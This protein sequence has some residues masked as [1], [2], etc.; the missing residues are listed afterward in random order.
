M[1]TRE[2]AR[3][4]AGP[5]LAA[6]VALVSVFTRQTGI[7]KAAT[8]WAED[9]HVFLGCHT[10]GEPVLNCLGEA[11]GGYLHLVPRV[12]ALL[13]WLAPPN[14]WSI[15]VTTAAA[16]ILG[17]AAFAIAAALGQATRSS[18]AG[19]IAGAALGLTYEAG[20]EVAGNLAN[21]HWILLVAA[22][23]IVVVTWLGRAPG[24]LDLAVVVG[25]ALSSPLMP[26]VAMLALAGWL[27]KRAGCGRLL[28]IT[29]VGSLIQA[30]VAATVPRDPPLHAPLGPG[31]ALSSIV[32]RVVVAGPFG[33]A[34][35]LP[36]WLIPALA[37]FA[38]LGLL[39]LGTREAQ[40]A[41]LAIG[42]L[43]VAGLAAYVTAVLVNRWEGPR[44]EYI[45]AAL[46]IEAAL[47]GAALLGHAGATRKAVRRLPLAVIAGAVLVSAAMSYRLESRTSRGP[48]FDAGFRAAVTAC[49]AGV[50]SALVPISPRLPD[51]TWTVEVPCARVAIASP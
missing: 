8:M 11:Y 9:G 42:A 35:P 7:P 29:S 18:L 51:R 49:D 4:V 17:V 6:A 2:R 26:I 20:H 23:V 45:P 33:P 36:G 50:E 5:G 44:Y 3:A 14:L 15:A 38:I 30:G 27:A 46:L 21:V 48:D 32:E 43:I 19:A 41:A 24:R 47:A 10:R 40:A 31:D 16:A 25:A 1:S 22:I 28:V 13:A 12:A 39:L 37:G 34:D